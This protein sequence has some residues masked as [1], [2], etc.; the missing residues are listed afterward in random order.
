MIK[1]PTEHGEITIIAA[2]GTPG[3][4]AITGAA[5]EPEIA[6]LIA[7]L[8][9]CGARIEADADSALLVQGRR[10]LTGCRH[11]VL[12]DSELQLIEVQLGKEISVHDKQKF[13]LEQETTR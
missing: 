1:V 4:T 3:E 9:G 5:R 6:D 7:Y 13:P 8:Q 12:A 10:E 2:A 11:T